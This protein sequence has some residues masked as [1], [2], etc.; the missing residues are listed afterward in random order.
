MN[1]LGKV[2]EFIDPTP[3]EDKYTQL[4]NR[5]YTEIF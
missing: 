2:Q 1:F 3:I 5:A 4:L